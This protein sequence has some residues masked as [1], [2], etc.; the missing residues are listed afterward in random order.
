MVNRLHQLNPSRFSS[1][2]SVCFS[3][4]KTHPDY[5]TRTI[6][7]RAKSR[8]VQA[9]Y[10]DEPL[11]ASHDR[12]ARLARQPGVGHAQVNQRSAWSHAGPAHRVMILVQ[13]LKQRA[14]QGVRVSRVYDACQRPTQNILRRQLQP[15]VEILAEEAAMFRLLWVGGGGLGL[16]LGRG[17][18][19][20][21]L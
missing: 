19:A 20:F 11:T 15:L 3:A 12:H 9:S 1:L 6:I 14:S 21:I 4:T 7:D 18:G 8:I 5:T 10:D 2:D 16:G 13:H 17:G